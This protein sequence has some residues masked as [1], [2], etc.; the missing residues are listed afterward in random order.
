MSKGK[1]VKKDRKGKKIKVG[2]RVRF[3]KFI[4]EVSVVGIDR[5]WIFRDKKS[6]LYKCDEDDYILKIVKAEELEVI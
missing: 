3:D 5:I 6:R 4:W 2:S 1:N